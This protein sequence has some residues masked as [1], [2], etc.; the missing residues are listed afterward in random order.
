MDSIEIKPF[1]TKYN[2]IVELSVPSSKSLSIRALILASMASGVSNIKDVLKSDD[3]ENCI[4][5][6]RDLGIEIIGN[7]NDFKVIGCGGIFPVIKDRIYFGSSGITS[8]FLLA[9]VCVSLSRDKKYHEIVV[10]G[11]EQLRKR[12]I[13]P[14]VDTLKAM[15]ANIRYIENE[16]FFP[17]LIKS[18]KLDTIDNVEVSGA[19]SSQY[20]SA[21]MMMSPLVGDKIKINVKDIK[22]SEHPYIKMAIETMKDFGIDSIHEFNENV[23]EIYPQPYRAVDFTVETDLNTA[24]YF[25]A[26]ASAVG[27]KIRIKNINV[28]SLQP[29]LQFFDVLR[30]MGCNVIF[31]DNDAILFGTKKLRGGFKINMFYMAEMTTLLSV[32]AVFADSPI[33][34]H[35]VKHIR[36]HESD[37]I[38][39]ISEE[40]RRA[41]IVVD[42]FEDGLRIF[43]GNPKFVEADSHED[44][45]IAMSLAV[46][47]AAGNGIKILNP[48][49]VSKTCPEFFELLNRFGA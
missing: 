6:L 17:L 12:T 31:K 21:I 4:N 29:G 22:S 28:D 46:L 49:C 1:S 11:S 5:A 32:L 48:R 30:K 23:Y 10:D 37:R 15:G 25:F 2:T 38:A 14:L 8:R 24:N 41:D 3:T 20:V 39:A 19:L 43:P 47:G 7:K 33:E 34:I 16:G 35:G 27:G 45:R 18:A 42:E 44:H 40:L 26:L 9:M 13:K 36:N